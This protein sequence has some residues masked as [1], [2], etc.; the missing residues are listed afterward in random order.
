MGGV[1]CVEEDEKVIEETKDSN[2]ADAMN[3][4]LASSVENKVGSILLV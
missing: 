1:M 4:I 2:F 3:K